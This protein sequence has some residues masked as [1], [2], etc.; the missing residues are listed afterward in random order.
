MFFFIVSSHSKVIKKISTLRR[1]ADGSSGNNSK[2][3]QPRLS[4]P[5][6]NISSP[7]PIAI[8]L[9]LSNPNEGTLSTSVPNTAKPKPS[10]PDK[11]VTLPRPAPCMDERSNQPIPK[12][13]SIESELNSKETEDSVFLLSTEDTVDFEKAEMCGPMVQIV[14]RRV[15]DK[16]LYYRPNSILPIQSD[17]DSDNASDKYFGSIVEDDDDE[18][19]YCL[20]ERGT[21]PRRQHGGNSHTPTSDIQ[22]G[23][24]SVNYHEPRPLSPQSLRSSESHPLEESYTSKTLPNRRSSSSS[25]SSNRNQQQLP[26]VPQKPPR[27][28]NKF[29]Q[30]NSNDSTESKDDANILSSTGSTS[31]T[32][33]EEQSPI[34]APHRNESGKPVVLVKPRSRHS[35][36]RAP[37]PPPLSTYGQSTV[38]TETNMSRGQPVATQNHTHSNN[39]TQEEEMK[40]E[41]EDVS[42]VSQS[43]SMYTNCPSASSLNKRF[44]FNVPP[45]SEGNLYWSGGNE[46]KTAYNTWS[47]PRLNAK[48]IPYSKKS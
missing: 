19:E 31:T 44:T 33:S 17:S 40:E 20:A 16:Q 26:T 46:K 2:T 6:Q 28:K 39:E 1:T 7:K 35:V 48:M 38:T 14:R 15:F 13:A 36:R 8:S 37:P 24:C 29:Q 5:K 23:S 47:D 30:R 32:T 18:E 42:R 3:L 43:S 4:N 21:L 11:L 45:S 9:P 41:K 10:L 27:R 34:S 12:P 22:E 25:S